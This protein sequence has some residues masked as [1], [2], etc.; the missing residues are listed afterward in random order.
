MICE[1]IRNTEGRNLTVLFVN[2]L[3]C[4][5]LVSCSPR[6]FGVIFSSE[7][8]LQGKRAFS[9]SLL[10]ISLWVFRKAYWRQMLFFPRPHDREAW[11]WLAKCCK[12]Q[13]LGHLHST[14]YIYVERDIFISNI[15]YSYSTIL[16]FFQ[17]QPKLSSFN[18][19][20]PSTSTKI[21]FIQEKYLFNFNLK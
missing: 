9:I 10:K 14:T 16:I 12:I 6:D 1:L 8:S 19:N 15:L 3:L 21:I 17:V 18:K 11:V 4:M 13:Q 20:I 7:K 2:N 5:I